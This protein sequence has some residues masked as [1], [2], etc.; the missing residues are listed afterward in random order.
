MIK[1]FILFFHLWHG[2]ESRDILHKFSKLL[3]IVANY[4]LSKRK[5]NK[6]NRYKNILVLRDVS[7]S[8]DIVSSLIPLSSP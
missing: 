1:V 8:V 7:N 5:N 4:Y 2:G 3:V 6:I